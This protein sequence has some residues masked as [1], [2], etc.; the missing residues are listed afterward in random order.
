MNAVLEM[1]CRQSKEAFVTEKLSR[2]RNND[3]A[4]WLAHILSFEVDFYSQFM[5]NLCSLIQ[6]RVSARV[7]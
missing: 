6:F 1:P 5:S 2:K 7:Q 4:C 3:F